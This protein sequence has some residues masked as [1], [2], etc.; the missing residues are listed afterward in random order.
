MH[1]IF[2]N[3]TFGR[4]IAAYVALDFVMGLAEIQAYFP[5]LLPAWTG[6]LDVK[7][8]V[9]NVASYLI[10]AQVGVLG[11]VSI[12]IGLVTIIAQRENASTDVQVYYHESLAFGV[13]ASSI[14]LLAVLCVELL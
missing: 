8:L 5:S 1:R 13:V 11:V 6:S 14:A 4:F 12:A 9:T 10:T 7:S 2:D 3:G